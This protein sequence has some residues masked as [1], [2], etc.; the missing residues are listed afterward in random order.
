MI[1]YH[2]ITSV[3]SIKVGIGLAEIG[4]DYDSQTLNLQM[5]DQHDAD[6][7]A[8]NPDVVVATLF[9]GDQVPV[10]SS[11]ILEYLDREY[12]DG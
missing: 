8:L 3:C 7:F 1:L 12:N 4:L 11:L 2:G 9:D 6:Y 10:K 5:G